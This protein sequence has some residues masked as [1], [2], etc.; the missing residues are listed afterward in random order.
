MRSQTQPLSL[1]L[2]FLVGRNDTTCVSAFHPSDAIKVAI[3][4]H[5]LGPVVHQVLIDI[6]GVNERRV[7]VVR[8]QAFGK[9]SE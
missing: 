4:L 9:L 6:V 3:I 1:L 8:E 7:S 2:A 5:G